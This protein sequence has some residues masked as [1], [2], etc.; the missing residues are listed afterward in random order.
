MLKIIGINGA[1]NKG[2][3]VDQLVS[4]IMNSIDSEQKETVFL[5]EQR[6]NCCLGCLNCIQTNRCVQQDDWD[7]IQSKL[8]DADV[9][10][11]GAPTYFSGAL[12]INALTHLFLERWFALRH[13]GVKL[14]LKKIVLAL[15]SANGVVEPA[16]NGLRTFFEV[17]HGLPEVEIVIAQGTM[18]CMVCGVG[19]TCQISGFI[20]HY[21]EGAKI[22]SDVLPALSKQME[23][24]SQAR[25]IA[26]N[27]M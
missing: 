25:T 3:T 15:A 19:E 8:M 20:R 6:I 12:G 9:L 1:P 13:L 10:V 5:R 24:I 22:T 23:V 7:S 2:G 18:P 4:F 11:L 16:V 27:I 21:G 14:K 17:Y 26:T